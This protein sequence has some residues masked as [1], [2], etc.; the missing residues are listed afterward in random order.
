MNLKRVIAIGPIWL[1]WP[2]GFPAGCGGGCSAYVSRVKWLML[3][4]PPFNARSAGNTGRDEM[5]A[6]HWACPERHKILT[7]RRNN[8]KCIR[9][10]HHIQGM[11]IVDAIKRSETHWITLSVDGDDLGKYW[12]SLR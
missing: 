8:E 6:D 4:L 12:W 11:R 5:V 9:K 2:G 1:R 3:P 7:C 10:N